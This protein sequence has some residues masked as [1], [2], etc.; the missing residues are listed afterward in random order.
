MKTCRAWM[1]ALQSSGWKRC[2]SRSG[3][4]NVHGGLSGVDSHGNGLAAA[5]ETGRA[6][7]EAATDW[8]RAPLSIDGGVQYRCLHHCSQSVVLACWLH[9]R[10]TNLEAM[11]SSS[12]DDIVELNV[13]GVFYTTTV[14][15]LTTTTKLLFTG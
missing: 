15:T 14:K 7:A 12:S 9:P 2:S 11:S 1:F 13:G 4:G 6:V 8:T 10:Q 5:G 3:G